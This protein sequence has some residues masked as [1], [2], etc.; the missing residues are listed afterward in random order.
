MP[1]LRVVLGA[2]ARILRQILRDLV[3][4]QPDMEVVGEVRTLA[5]LP[6]A[7]ESCRAEAVILT[8]P[9]L[10]DADILCALRRDHPGLTFLAIAGDHDRAAVWPAGEDPRPIEV[11]AAGILIALRQG[12]PSPQHVH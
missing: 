1:R 6:K 8:L 5:G 10:D 12:R 2:M 11:S 4:R 3:D 9:P 7:I